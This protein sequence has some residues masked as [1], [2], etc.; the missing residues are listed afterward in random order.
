MVVVGILI[1]QLSQI[2]TV[3]GGPA[4]YLLALNSF[5]TEVVL[6][7]ERTA[8]IGRLTGCAMYVLSWRGIVQ[9]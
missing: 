1:I 9:S 2:I 3:I 7:N 8:T 5:A 4:G 6:P